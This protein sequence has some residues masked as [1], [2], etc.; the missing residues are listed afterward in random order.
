MNSEDLRAC[1]RDAQAD[2]GDCVSLHIGVFVPQIDD[3][4]L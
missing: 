2:Y 1:S 3:Q 4:A